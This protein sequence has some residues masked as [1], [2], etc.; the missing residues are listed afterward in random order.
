MKSAT[1]GNDISDPE[2]TNI[3]RHGVWLLLESEELFLPFEHFPWFKNAP[4]GKVLRVE[5]PSSAH[6]YW[7]DLDIDLAVESIR[8]PD[9]FPLISR[10]AC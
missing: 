2:V 9:R 8:H 1:L 7:P 3:S 10:D 4:I 5:Q 6:V